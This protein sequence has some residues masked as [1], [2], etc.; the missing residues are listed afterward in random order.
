[1]RRSSKPQG[2]RPPACR[3]RRLPHLRFRR[4][5][6]SATPRS[7]RKASLRARRSH[8]PRRVIKVLAC[9][10]HGRRSL[11]RPESSI[12]DRQ[13][14]H[15]TNRASSTEYISVA[16]RP[17]PR[18]R[19]AASPLCMLV[20]H[21]VRYVAEHTQA[22]GCPPAARRVQPAQDRGAAVAPIAEAAKIPAACLGLVACRPHP[23]PPIAAPSF[24][25]LLVQDV[26][27]IE[28]AFALH[29]HRS[30]RRARD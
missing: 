9:A 18:P 27:Q 1:M 19:I 15:R 20:V 7:S 30:V 6:L 5:T 11:T 25:V 12:P 13:R 21:V 28:D 4:R 10:D 14:D 2:F 16:L 23:R 8:L 17:P 26:R 29:S 3:A 24:G 22:S